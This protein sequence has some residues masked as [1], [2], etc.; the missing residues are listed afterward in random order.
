VIDFFNRL[1]KPPVASGATAKER[2]RLVLLSDH[3]QL[4]PDVIDALKADLL[5]VIQRYVEIDSAHADVTFEHRE[6]EIAMLANI[7]ITGVRERT[8]ARAATAPAPA[9]PAPATAAPATVKSPSLAPV[10]PAP[11][12]AQP[13]NGAAH[14]GGGTS[15]RRRRKKSAAANA[16]RAAAQPAA[17]GAI[18]KPAQA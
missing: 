6:S 13:V 3:L 15:R 14:A 9:T 2:L 4:A 1:F 16:R 7:P 18:G 17:G 11:A 10:S 8:A 12:D 5:A